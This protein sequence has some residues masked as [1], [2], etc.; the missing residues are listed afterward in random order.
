VTQLTERIH[1]LWWVTVPF[2]VSRAAIGPGLQVVSVS[3]PFGSSLPGGP[4]P[5]YALGLA[6]DGVTSDPQLPGVE[7][8]VRLMVGVIKGPTSTGSMNFAGGSFASFGLPTGYLSIAEQSLA[9]SYSINYTAVAASVRLS[10]GTTE[11]LR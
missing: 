7:P 10:A 3:I 5:H 11:P 1:G 2:T 6:P 8:M 9:S 4:A